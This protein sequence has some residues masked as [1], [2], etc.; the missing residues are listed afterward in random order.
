[1][2]F[3][4]LE[5]SEPALSL[6]PTPTGFYFGADS[7]YS[8]NLQT[9]KPMFVFFFFL[10]L[11]KSDDLGNHGC[12]VYFLFLFDH[13]QLLHNFLVSKSL[14][15]LFNWLTLE[16]FEKCEIITR[17]SRFES[18]KT[19]WP[20]GVGLPHRSSASE[21]HRAATSL[22]ELA[23]RILLFNSQLTFIELL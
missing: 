9:A 15:L 22:S 23:I 4:K 12:F 21:W 18:A 2:I 8:V 7:F 16:M 1:M 14:I 6:V 13:S 5:T 17:G 19:G 3:E 20:R 10:P 11:F